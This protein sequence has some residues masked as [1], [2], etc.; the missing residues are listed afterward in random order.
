T[1]FKSEEEG[2]VFGSEYIIYPEDEPNPLIKAI[3]KDNVNG[4][5]YLFLWFLNKYPLHYLRNIRSIINHYFHYALYFDAR[6]M[7]SLFLSSQ[8]LAAELKS[9]PVKSLT[10]GEYN[11]SQEP[12]ISLL[13]PTLLL[14]PSFISNYT[15]RKGNSLK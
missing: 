6:E 10:L 1:L 5:K 3:E 14:D 11:L 8:S 4:F 9:A 7:I 12:L 13:Y 15:K 2:T